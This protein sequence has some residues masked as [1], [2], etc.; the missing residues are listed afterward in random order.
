MR[1]WELAEELVRG[2]LG[3]AYGRCLYGVAQ[4]IFGHM[5]LKL[6]KLSRLEYILG[7]FQ[8]EQ[9]SSKQMSIDNKQAM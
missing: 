3:M 8:Y 4:G 6:G 7:S 9:R 1:W 2:K 5:D